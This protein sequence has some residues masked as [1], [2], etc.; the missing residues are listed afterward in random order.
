[1]NS[2]C[3][4]RLTTIVVFISFISET[5]SSALKLNS[6]F[7]NMVNFTLYDS[8]AELKSN[9][10]YDFNSFQSSNYQKT[11]QMSNLLIFST[12]DKYFQ[13]LNNEELRAII[14]TH[15]SDVT[16]QLKVFKALSECRN[17][18][19]T[20]ADNR[21]SAY[22]LTAYLKPTLK[23]TQNL[24]FNAQIDE[25]FLTNDFKK[26]TS[27]FARGATAIEL[28]W[29]YDRNLLTTHLMRLVG[30]LSTL[31]TRDDGLCRYVFNLLGQIQKRDLTF[32]LVPAD[33]EPWLHCIS[34]YET[35]NIIMNW[36]ELI[37]NN[38]D[39][40]KPESQKETVDSLTDSVN[41]AIESNLRTYQSELARLANIGSKVS[42]I[43]INDFVQ[44]ASRLLNIPNNLQFDAS[45]NPLLMQVLE[46]NFVTY[47]MNRHRSHY[48]LG[49]LLSLVT[50]EDLENQGL[51]SQIEYVI[52]DKTYNV[53]ALPRE[54]IQFIADS[55][56]STKPQQTRE[57]LAL[58]LCELASGLSLIEFESLSSQL[59]SQLVEKCPAFLET[60]TQTQKLIMVD[61]ITNDLSI[62]ALPSNLVPYL[63]ILETQ[64]LTSQI[65]LPANE[66]KDYLFQSEIYMQIYSSKRLSPKIAEEMGSTI[67]GMDFEDLNDLSLVDQIDILRIYGSRKTKFTRSEAQFSAKMYRENFKK[68]NIL[69]DFTIQML[70]H[71][72]L[73]F[74]PAEIFLEFE[75]NE[76]EGVN[77]LACQNIFSRVNDEY[78]LE[79]PTSRLRML[80]KVYM[81]NC[82]REPSKRLH[83][84][85]TQKDVDN[86][87]HLLCYVPI[88]TINDMSYELLSNGLIY[89][90]KCQID[91][92]IAQVIPEKLHFLF[93]TPKKVEDLG[94][95][96]CSVF[97]LDNNSTKR[98]YVQKE[99]YLSAFLK[100]LNELGK[101][102]ELSDL[103]SKCAEFVSNL[104]TQTIR[105]NSISGL[106]SLCKS[107]SDK[108]LTCPVIRSL[109]WGNSF[110]EASYFQKYSSKCDLERCSSYIKEN[111]KFFKNEILAEI[112]GTIFPAGA[113]ITR[114]QVIKSAHLLPFTK[115]NTNS[116][117]NLFNDNNPRSF[118]VLESLGKIEGFRFESDSFSRV[119]ETVG[120]L[121]LW[122]VSVLGN[123]MCE[124]PMDLNNNAIKSYFESRDQLKQSIPIIGQLTTCSDRFYSNFANLAV[125]LF[126]FPELNITPLVIAKLG[127]LVPFL[128][129]SWLKYASTLTLQAV[130]PEIVNK[131]SFTGV[132]EPNLKRFSVEQ[133]SKL[134]DVHLNRMNFDQLEYI[135]SLTNGLA[136]AEFS[137]YTTTKSPQSEV[138]SE[139]V[140]PEN[141]DY[142]S[143]NYVRVIYIISNVDKLF[144][145]VLLVFSLHIFI[146]F[147]LVRTL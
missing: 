54:M 132:I 105:S 119:Y 100:V 66:I 23:W 87:R 127:N 45:H 60:A 143:E 35:E 24:G 27:D 103:Q 85:M 2:S 5:F 72:D 19:T 52:E 55:Y 135:H 64:N 9:I 76:W 3:L 141:Y 16:T 56:R 134:S 123:L 43:G 108:F 97:K 101:E 139:S 49:Q 32:R 8:S 36:K 69:P 113:E 58:N 117:L 142:F 67:L 53:D 137:S 68:L 106:G 147:F 133:I 42:L 96:F 107:G 93:I 144:S 129:P 31:K 92:K 39:T 81:N 15:P 138:E 4:R 33:I 37:L 104:V 89:F 82:K 109:T 102:R 17:V 146:R 130:Q 79:L 73:F 40:L 47:S 84:P 118:E 38:L 128:N 116:I 46:D 22:K 122:K 77:K 10:Q 44:L 48:P 70:P 25:V 29:L 80:A 115:I 34:P 18:E 50:P 20:C 110:L 145:N 71:Q 120:P 125:D 124:L 41:W 136:E 126:R 131:L 14:E 78:I 21:S 28:Q 11:S 1:M 75:E 61:K 59:F 65:D 114:E 30:S 121:N 74:M 62:T 99:Y 6:E 12:L 91:Q 90:S 13:Q 63:G 88:K 86:L 26:V 112:A 98:L 111:K 83:E 51:V 140:L 7:A 57:E 95:N 94:A